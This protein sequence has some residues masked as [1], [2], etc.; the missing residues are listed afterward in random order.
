MK[1]FEKY[2]LKIRLLKWENSCDGLETGRFL[3]RAFCNIATAH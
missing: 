1:Q 2:L 3:V